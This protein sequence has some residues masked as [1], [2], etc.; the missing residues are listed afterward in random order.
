MKPGKED[1]IR[2]KFPRICELI[3]EIKKENL[4]RHFQNFKQSIE[5]EAVNKKIFSHVE[6]DLKF[7]DPESWKF[8]KHK[9]IQSFKQKKPIR[10]WQSGFDTLNEAKCYRYLV[11]YKNAKDVKFIAESD[12]RGHKTPDLCGKIDETFVICEVKTINVSECEAKRRAEAIGCPQPVTVGPL[13]KEF[14]DKLKDTREEAA[15]QLFNFSPDKTNIFVIYVVLHFD[16]N[17]HEHVEHYV[18]QIKCQASDMWIEK[19]EIVFDVKPPF[20]FAT[21]DSPAAQLYLLHPGH[22]LTQLEG[23]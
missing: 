21:S 9:L 16:D 1:N 3:D 13:P 17:L 22:T 18:S 6:E 12:K 19:V 2:E 15:K 14:F 10:G 4:P 23:Y 8:L 5:N 20:Y 11:N 7:L